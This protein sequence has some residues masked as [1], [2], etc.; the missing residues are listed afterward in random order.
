MSESRTAYLV[1][2]TSLSS[3]SESERP[4]FWDDTHY[5]PLRDE[6][7]G[8]VQVPEAV[9]LDRYAAERERGRRESAARELVN[10][11]WFGDMVSVSSLLEADFRTK[12]GE[13]GLTPPPVPATEY[14]ADHLVAWWDS[15]WPNW[16]ADQ[17]ADVWE[18]LDKARLFDVVEVE[19]E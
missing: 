13:L 3:P 2:R 6:D 17:R 19:L 12:V 11:F 16:T 4:T 5:Q 9:F 14:G 7:R 10:P 18:L 8:S 1:V 15:E